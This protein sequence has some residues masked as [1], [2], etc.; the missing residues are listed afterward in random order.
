MVSHDNTVSLCGIYCMAM[1]HILYI[2]GAFNII[3][4][5]M[6]RVN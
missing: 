3:I 1:W 2:I 6:I 4:L 5:G